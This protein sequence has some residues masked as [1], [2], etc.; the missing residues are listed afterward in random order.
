M[1]SYT[2][3][4]RLSIGHLGI[5]VYLAHPSES[6]AYKNNTLIFAP[7]TFNLFSAGNHTNTDQFTFKTYTI[8]LATSKK[9]QTLFQEFAGEKI[10]S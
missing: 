4:L 9:G 3:F 1:S 10:N 5:C 7:N 6:K 2:Q 8:I